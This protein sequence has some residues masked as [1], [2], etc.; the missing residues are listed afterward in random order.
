MSRQNLSDGWR[1]RGASYGLPSSPSGRERTCSSGCSRCSF[2][3]APPRAIEARPAMRI[4]ARTLP[5]ALDCVVQRDRQL[6]NADP[7]CCCSWCWSALRHA[8][9]AVGAAERARQEDFQRRA[10]LD[11]KAKTV[12]ESDLTGNSTAEGAL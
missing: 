7:N 12:A 8:R 5:V 4:A 3:N 9:V 6:V 1:S 2:N 11:N 10:R